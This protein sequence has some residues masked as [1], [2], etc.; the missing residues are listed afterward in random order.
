MDDNLIEIRK[1]ISSLMNESKHIE[2]C[3]YLIAHDKLVINKA[4]NM[5]L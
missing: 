1:I 4:I 2:V 5:I 3:R